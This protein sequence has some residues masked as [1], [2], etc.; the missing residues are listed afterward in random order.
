MICPVH[1]GAVNQLERELALVADI[2]LATIS[3]EAGDREVDPLVGDGQS[4]NAVPIHG[5]PIALGR[6]HDGL[7]LRRKFVPLHFH[8]V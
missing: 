5:A 1:R 2:N 3:G 6:N 8:H 7:N 4:A